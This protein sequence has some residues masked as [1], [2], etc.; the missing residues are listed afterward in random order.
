MVNHE[1][2]SNDVVSAPLEAS[3]PGTD[4]SR[5]S[6]PPEDLNAA[7]AALDHPRRRFLVSALTARDGEQPLASLAAD[8]A[9]WEADQP[10]ED[11]STEARQRCRIALH[12]VHIPK[13]AAFGIVDYDTDGEPTVRAADTDGVSAVFDSLDTDLER[14]PG[15]APGRDGA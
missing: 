6:A 1:P 14:D 5:G 12:H 8:L 10:R 7:F 4:S 11:V 15:A 9:A 2:S 3:R 13:L